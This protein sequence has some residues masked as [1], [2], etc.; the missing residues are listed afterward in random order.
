MYD[1]IMKKREGGI[2]D[3]GEIK[4]FVDGYTKDEIP[5]YQASALLMAIFYKG[6]T[7]EET[8]NLTFAMRDSGEILDLS[9]VNGIKVDKHSTGGVGDKTT[10]A[11][12]PTVAACG[13]KMAKMSGRG[14]GHTGGTIDKL[15]SIKGFRT[16]LPREEFLRIADENGFAITGQSGNLTPADKKLYA[17]RDTTATV[18]SPP[19]IASSI[20][21]K[22]LAAG[23][24]CILL[25]VKTGSG[26]FMK[27]FEDAQ[28]LATLMTKIGAAANKKVN[29]VI[30]DMDTPLG[31]AVGNS[32]EVIEAVETLRGR[33]PK[34]FTELCLTLSAELSTMA[35]LGSFNECFRRAKQAIDSGKAFEK[36]VKTVEMQGGDIDYIYNTDLFPKA[37]YA[38]DVK[39]KK[40]GYIRNT[41]AAAYGKASLVTGAGRTKKGD[42]IDYS[43]GLYVYKKTGDE[44][45]TGDTV[46]TLYTNKE[47]ALDEAEKIVLDATGIGDEPE[48]MP[49]VLGRV[50]GNP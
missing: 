42:A 43:A 46:A 18:D 6:M 44:V 27:T 38:R 14:L 16:E 25:D 8:A 13:L 48:K 36:F 5:D 9:S 17:L 32:L 33:G 47:S 24:D 22:K 45:N 41:D 28:R 50:K 49:L 34:D 7:D 39:V 3:G 35:G 21:S 31:N 1:I 10:L 11:V 20:M 4:Y 19:L 2:L 30:T 29:A 12:A 15:E 37:K 26:A 23:G 40:G